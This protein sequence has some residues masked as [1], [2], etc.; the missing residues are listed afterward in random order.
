MRDL[1]VHCFF[2][3]CIDISYIANIVSAV[4]DFSGCFLFSYPSV[5]EPDFAECSRSE[6]TM[7]APLTVSARSGGRRIIT[8]LEFE[9]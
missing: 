9:G 5:G 2:A 4:L 7:A 6:G 3:D 1:S 8:V